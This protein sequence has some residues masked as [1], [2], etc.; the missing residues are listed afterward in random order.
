VARGAIDQR[1]LERFARSAA[2]ARLARIRTE[3]IGAIRIAGANRRSHSAARH[4]SYSL[5][6]PRRG[7]VGQSVAANW[8]RDICRGSAVVRFLQDGAVAADDGVA[9]GDEADPLAW[10]MVWSLERSLAL[11]AQ[12]LGPSCLAQSL[13]ARSSSA[14]SSRKAARP[15]RS[16]AA[17][18]RRAPECASA[19][20]SRPQR[21]RSRLR[22][23]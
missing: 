16:G 22:P 13:T 14:A 17:D 11:S 15:A 23:K 19:A 7:W 5:A 1:K 10:R 21:R 4:R 8:E 18:R 20:S 12:I 6:V 3:R 9:G 2:A